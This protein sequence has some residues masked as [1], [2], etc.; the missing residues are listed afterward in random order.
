MNRWDWRWPFVEP[1]LFH[2]HWRPSFNDSCLYLLL[3]RRV[4]FLK[5]W[6][7]CELFLLACASTCNVIFMRFHEL[8]E[9]I[10]VLDEKNK[11]I[12]VSKIAAKKVFSLFSFPAMD[13]LRRTNSRLWL[14]WR[15]HVLFYPYRFFSFHQW[16]CWP[17]KSKSSLL[18][19]PLI[20]SSRILLIRNLLRRFPRLSLPMNTLACTLSFGLALP[21]S[22]ALFPQKA[23][24]NSAGSRI[25]TWPFSVLFV[26]VS[27]NELEKELQAKTSAPYVYYNKGL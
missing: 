20:V 14:K 27:I 18:E 26:Q 13:R 10:E 23:K 16:L 21:M 7:N 3:V 8:Y 22:I 19:D 9:G 11:S 5:P 15:W 2:P 6:F 24:V 12:G 25:R 4:S 1:K 17:S